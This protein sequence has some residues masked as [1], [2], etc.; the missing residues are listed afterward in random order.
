MSTL[1]RRDAGPT[2]SDLWYRVEGTSPRLSPHAHV[3]RQLHPAGVSFIVEDPAGAAYYR[4]TE[5]AAF[6]LGLL[7]G[8]RTVG[9]AWDSCVAQRGDEAPTQRECL[10]L[11]GKLQLYGLLLGELPL[12]PD[13]VAERKRQAREKRVAQTTGKGLF[14]NLP[15][16]NPEPFLER[17]RRFFERCFSGWGLAAWLL[18]VATALYH[19]L[20]R[21]SYR[22][23]ARNFVGLLD[24]DNLLLLS[25]GFLVMR[26]LHELGHAAACK[27]RGGRVTEIGLMM[28][29]FVLPIPY[30]DASS[31]WRFERA[32]D[33]VL[34]AAAGVLTEV[35]FA[36]IAAII[37]SYTS[38]PWLV[39]LCF[40]IMVLSGVT[41]IVFNLN[42][43]LRYDG[44]YIL[45][46][47]LGIPNLAQKSRQ[48]W[49]Y[50][51]Q[52]VAFGA[53]AV[54]PPEV[55]SA[56][57]GW[58]LA[59]YGTL[60]TPYRLF[61]MVSILMVVASRYLGLGMALAA[62]LVA[63]WVVWPLVKAVGF[64][65]SAPQL[66]GHRPRAIGV[67][68]GALALLLGVLGLVPAPA[69]SVASGVIGPA[70]QRPVRVPEGGFLV[71]AA[72]A[73]GAAVGA[74][75]ALFEFESRELM[76]DLAMAR[77][78]LKKAE[79]EYNKA[80]LRGTR[81][82]ERVAA[83][84]V[85]N[86]RAERDRLEQRAGALEILAPASG[87][88][89]VA[90]PSVLDPANLEG[91]Y[92][93]RGTLLGFVSSLDDRIVR[94]A[95]SDK[96][97]AYIFRQSDIAAA[98]RR[99]EAD[100]IE[101]PVRIRV[102]GQF[103]ETV[104]GHSARR[105]PAGSRDLPDASLGTA[106]GGA[107]APDPDDSSGHRTLVPLFVLEIRGDA[108]LP[109]SWKP[110]LRASVRFDLPPEPLLSQWWRRAQQ[111]VKGRLG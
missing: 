99:G 25:V 109:E 7:D 52:R 88:F 82:E 18:V 43:L 51:V 95:V 110:G 54:R 17:H 74:D 26:S 79:A 81:P 47:L 41:T 11:L 61:V 84:E 46:D 36:A 58:I 83:R 67:T 90:N 111:Y 92:F 94:V 85:E 91:R 96:E 57:E 97:A 75:Q 38:A 66:I 22:D 10:D 103:G 20:A 80:S 28:I 12:A 77:A 65:V 49:Q 104:R 100:T 69:G 2:F 4:I 50:M 78:R 13:M 62:V 63:V 42:P 98:L 60:A 44:Y 101:L 72:A 107:F 39:S 31:S 68:L 71:R 19:V 89:V 106:A 15:L 93:K 70:V 23:D 3:T 45:S 5:P 6:F 29:A 73:P 108:A 14:P 16:I 105:V 76:T 32:R 1:L 86:A 48:L 53:R 8:D 27:A 55:R 35:F 30:C 87:T 102:P 34:V 9:E 64:M 56:G 33:R 37:W 59:V 24:P 40:N 21:W